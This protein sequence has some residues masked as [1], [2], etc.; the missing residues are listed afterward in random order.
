MR[1]ALE[2][3]SA[4][5]A[6]MMSMPTQS[7]SLQARASRSKAMRTPG[8]RFAGG[9]IWEERGNGLKAIADWKRCLQRL[10]NCTD[11]AEK[12]SHYESAAAPRASNWALTYGAA[13]VLALIVVVGVL[14]K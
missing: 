6:A 2:R 5:A 14:A 3:S 12:L 7:L 8:V 13:A 10:P 9:L 1:A 4:R 11:A